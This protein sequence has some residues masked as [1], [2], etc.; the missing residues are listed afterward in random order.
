MFEVF[1]KGTEL[2]A[3]IAV[4]VFLG[5]PVVFMFLN[6]V[7]FLFWAIVGLVFYSAEHRAHLHARKFH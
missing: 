2:I 4:L 3:R 5:F 6:L 1:F 7:R